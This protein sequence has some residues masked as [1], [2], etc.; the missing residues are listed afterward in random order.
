MAK[1]REAADDEASG[2]DCFCGGEV[3][4]ELNGEKRKFTPFVIL[5]PKLMGAVDFTLRS[6]GIVDVPARFSVVDSLSLGGD[7]K[8]A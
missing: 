8:V 3:A 4:G 2:E 5:C 6:V 1:V 7:A